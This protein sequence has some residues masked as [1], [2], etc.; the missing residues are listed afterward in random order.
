MFKEGDKVRINLKTLF[1]AHYNSGNRTGA[2][3]EKIAYSFEGMMLVNVRDQYTLS[4]PAGHI[5]AHDGDV[6]SINGIDKYYLGPRESGTLF[7]ERGIRI[8][9]D[10]AKACIHPVEKENSFD[11]VFDDI[12]QGPNAETLA[13]VKAYGKLLVQ[14]EKKQGIDVFHAS[15]YSFNNKNW[16]VAYRNGELLSFKEYTGELP[17]EAQKAEA[18]SKRV[19]QI[20]VDVEIDAE[21]NGDDLAEKIAENLEGSGYV[22][23]GSAFQ[24]D[25]S[26]EYDYEVER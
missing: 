6:L 5:L 24:A 19:V 16:F 1:N 17:K 23:L 20:S 11:E 13:N 7:L 26:K 10:E 8:T 21:E 22:V 18:P 25:M 15:I 4:H 14:K 2:N 3:G 12:V 9:F